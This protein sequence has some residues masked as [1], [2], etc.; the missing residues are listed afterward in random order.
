VTVEKKSF[1]TNSADKNIYSMTT[2]APVDCSALSDLAA[3]VLDLKAQVTALKNKLDSHGYTPRANEPGRPGAMIH[4][5]AAGDL[6][7]GGNFGQGISQKIAFNKN[8]AEFVPVCRHSLCI[9][10]GAKHWH[11]DCPHTRDTAVL[12]RSRVLLSPRMPS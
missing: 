12:V 8:K 9:K 1:A 7:T 3:I 5:L 6:P 2:D 11:R 10:A 4:R